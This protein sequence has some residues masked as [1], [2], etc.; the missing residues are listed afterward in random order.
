VA[1][2]HSREA[3][4]VT[5]PAS[6]MPLHLLPSGTGSEP[7]VDWFDLGS[8]R[9]DAP[10]FVETV[11]RAQCRH[12]DDPQSGPFRRQTPMSDLMDLAAMEPVVS[13]TGFIFH[14]ARCGSTLVSQMLAALPEH[15][16]LAEAVPID[17]ALRTRFWAGASEDE[18]AG[19]LRAVVG[20][21]GR[22]RSDSERHLFIKFDAWHVTELPLIRQAFPD[23]PW[24]FLYRD[25][26]E[27][28]VS[29]DRSTAALTIPGVIPPCV[30]GL[31]H[32]AAATLS[33]T[34]YAAQVTAA[35][36]EAALAQIDGLGRLVRY[37]ELP[38]ALPAILSHF[39]IQPSAAELG[40]MSEVAGEDSKARGMPFVPDSRTK[41]AEASDE[42]WAAAA[43]LEPVIQRLDEARRR[44]PAVVA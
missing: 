11:Y 27:V 32:V 39:G 4:N 31:D 22:R 13:P 34:A 10:F 30:F 23:T 24:I 17:G 6:W 3:V 18:R 36:A 15:I 9:F 40:Q 35:I 1:I 41:R 25:P 16:V 42:I 2:D 28:L 37:D 7:T 19:W 20:A 38:A 44:E 26:V 33:P 5:A 43:R 8:L 12:E 14:L 29:H 21:L